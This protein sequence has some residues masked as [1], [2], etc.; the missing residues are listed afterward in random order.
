MP[1]VGSDRLGDLGP[2][3][4][5]TR[6]LEEAHHV[7]GREVFEPLVAAAGKVGPARLGTGAT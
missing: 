2:R 4:F 7:I 3:A 5:H 6:S 1:A